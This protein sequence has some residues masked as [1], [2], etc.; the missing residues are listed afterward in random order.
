V[1]AEASDFWVYLQCS[2]D[3]DILDS[4]LEL[5]TEARRLAEAWEAN[6]VRC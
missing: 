6:R 2:D 1:T 4:S 3:H 5:L